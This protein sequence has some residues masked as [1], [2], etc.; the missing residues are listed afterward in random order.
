MGASANEI[1][2]HI[3]ET[4]DVDEN[5]GELEE[6]TSNVVR[7]GKVAAVAL[8]VVVAGGVAFMLYRRFRKQ[9]L[10]DRLQGMSMESLRDLADETAGRLKKPLPS[11]TLTV[12]DRSA[13]GPGMHQSIVRKVPPAIV[14]TPSTPLIEKVT[15]PSGAGAETARAFLGRVQ[16]FD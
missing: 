11:L 9:T 1:D 6:A 4:R 12:I 7:Y 14:G 5:L 15:R 8:G 13:G 16:A 3:K 10:K 2:R